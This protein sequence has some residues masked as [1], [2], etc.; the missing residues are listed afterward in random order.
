MWSSA[1]VMA[2]D[3]VEEIISKFLL[4]TSQQNQRPHFFVSSAA[5]GCVDVVTKH[6]PDTD[7]VNFIPLTTGSAAEFYI[8]PMLSCVGDIDVMYHRNDQLAIPA[9]T[10]PPTQLL[11]LIF[12]AK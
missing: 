11:Q 8:Q 3:R 1:T 10:R 9:G 6:P 7:E 5:L 4:D 2:D 12:T